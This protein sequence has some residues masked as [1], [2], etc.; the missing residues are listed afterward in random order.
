LARIEPSAEADEIIDAV[1][2][3]V[4]R[5]APR[6]CDLAATGRGAVD[7]RAYK[8]AG[9]GSAGDRACKTGRADV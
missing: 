6:S 7:D 5:E 8:T 4:R 9:K 3:R 1:A 2:D